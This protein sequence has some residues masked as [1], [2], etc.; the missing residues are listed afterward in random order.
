[1]TRFVTQQEPL[2]GPSDHRA[3]SQARE[4][5]ERANRTLLRKPIT[6]VPLTGT[7]V[8]ITKYL[9]LIAAVPRTSSV[10]YSSPIFNKKSHLMI[11]VSSSSNNFDRKGKAK[12]SELTSF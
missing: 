4:H 8:R 5:E 9:P 12:L 6:S 2:I 11:K 10:S 7:G 1:M 3:S